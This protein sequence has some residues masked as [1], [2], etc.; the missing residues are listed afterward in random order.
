MLTFAAEIKTITSALDITVKSITM[1][2][3][4][5]NEK[6]MTSEGRK[7]LHTEMLG[8]IQNRMDNLLKNAPEAN[9]PKIE[10]MFKMAMNNIKENGNSIL[11]NFFANEEISDREF[12]GNVQCEI[13]G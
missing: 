5:Y 10:K 11:F 13:K 9:K 4:E 6:S 1:T 8:I 2:R 3:Q 12:I 7:N